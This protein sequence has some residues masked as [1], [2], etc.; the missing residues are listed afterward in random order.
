MQHLDGI[1]KYTSYRVD[2]RGPGPNGTVID[3][4]NDVFQNAEFSA[5]LRRYSDFLWLYERLHK[6][7]AGAIV[8]PVPDKQAVS[9]FSPDFIEERR[10]QLERF[11]RRVAVH[12]ELYDAPSLDTFLRADDMTFH[13][14]KNA[15]GQAA[16]MMIMSVSQSPTYNA[17]PPPAKKDGFKKWFAQAKTTLSGD[18]VRSADDD[19]FYDIERYIDGLEKQMKSVQQ[20]ASA[21]VK[22]GKETANGL[23]EFG[24]AFTLLG[25]SEA[26]ALGAA[27]GKVGSAAD[28]LS[29]LSAEQATKEFAKFEEPLQD[30][31]K[32]IYAV[33]LALQRRH[34]NRLA[35]TTCLS[36]VSSKE[37]Q[38]QKLRCTPGSEAKAYGMEISLQRKQK[39]AEIM[40][41]EF[42]TVS[43][44]VLREVD[45]FK[46]EKAEDM[47]FI[48]LDY[49][50]LQINFN[51]NMEEIWA[52]VLPQLEGVQVSELD[53]VKA[54][55]TVQGAPLPSQHEQDESLLGNNSMNM[56]SVNEPSVVGGMQYRG[57]SA[58]PS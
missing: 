27:L 4:K 53:H 55:N 7:R 49:I 47:R 39:E 12:P 11:L 17:M 13:A 54:A 44:R 8:P 30:Y 22:K 40:K 10:R 21:L 15:K 35:Y 33:K 36:E 14:A 19:L 9:R 16:E 56:I 23:F 25:Q 43:Q 42:A 1:N 5:V 48:V 31:I 24:L 20:Q 41:E 45:R 6:E 18:L 32:S 50:T 3:D 57:Q 37:S 28:S 26:D 2:V 46:R 29:K 34:D 52:S 51:K 58:L 38:L